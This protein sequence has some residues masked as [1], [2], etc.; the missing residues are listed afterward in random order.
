ML[1]EELREM[2]EFLKDTQTDTSFVEIKTCAGGFPKRIWE[3]V[4]AFSNTPGGGIII[5]GIDEREEDINIVGV[6][7]PAKF[8][9]LFE[10]TCSESRCRGHNN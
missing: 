10:E 8:Q 5:L 6:K 3:T 4:S 2:I 1:T 9:K 7:E